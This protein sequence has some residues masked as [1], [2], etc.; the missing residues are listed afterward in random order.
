MGNGTEEREPDDGL[1]LVNL[2]LKGGMITQQQWLDAFAEKTRDIKSGKQPR[3]LTEI[4]VSKGLL[5]PEQLADLRK[6]KTEGWVVPTDDPKD[7]ESTPVRLRTVGEETKQRKFGKYIIHGKLLADARVKI[8]D[9]VDSSANRPVALR[10]LRTSVASDPGAAFRDD[11]RFVNDAEISKTLTHPNILRVYEAGV[12]EGRRYIA[13]ESVRGVSMNEWLQ[14]EVSL[15][16]KV[17][18]LRDV[19]LAIHHAHEQGIIHQ[20][21]R[22]KNVLV[23]ERNQPRVSNFGLARAIRQDQNAFLTRSAFAAETVVYMSPEQAENP[24]VSDRKTDIYAVGVILYEIITGTAPHRGKTA[25]ETLMKKAQEEVPKPSR[26][27]SVGPSGVDRELEK[28]C[29]K[30]LAK[31]PASRHPTAKALADDLTAWIKGDKIAGT[32]RPGKRFLMIGSIAVAVL[33]AAG[34]LLLGPG[35]KSPSPEDGKGATP[36]GNRFEPRKRLILVGHQKTVRAIVFRPGGGGVISAGNDGTIRVWD[37][38]T[39]KEQDVLK[40]HRG[41]VRSIALCPAGQILA[42][43]GTDRTVILWDVS[44]G[45]QLATLEGHN[46]EVRGV[47]F[48]PGGRSLASSGDDGRVILWD[49]A[50]RKRKAMLHEGTSGVRCLAFSPDGKTLAYEDRKAMVTLLDLAARRVRAV[51]EGHADDVL[52]VAYSPD[53]KTIA[54]GAK[55]ATVRLWN[56]EGGKARAV[57]KG[58]FARVRTLAFSPDGK[59]LASGGGGG[60]IMIWETATGKQQ[61]VFQAHDRQVWSTAF[62]PDGRILASGSSDD[63]VIL[64]D[65]GEGS[66]D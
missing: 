18:L 19:A 51:L 28:I 66:G 25:V 13:S 11:E 35:S 33:V 64:W 60:R 36:A 39:G 46:G 22:P 26:A 65:V 8:Y 56:R 34:F 21:I 1:E 23:D 16:Q 27:K 14:G 24:L 55:D 62:S 29:M 41:E 58:H 9:A 3:H 54:T 47:A 61:A 53:G 31:N 38:A 42:S 2:A 20:D 15:W 49:V 17:T 57:L 48:S 45:R 52:A 5:T 50:A 7:L 4:L 63:T 40:A 6:R 37:A 10:L 12:I 59:L 32:G 30:A 44:T 43:G